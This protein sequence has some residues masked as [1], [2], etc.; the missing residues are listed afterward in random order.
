MMSVYFLTYMCE[1]EEYDITMDFAIYSSE[2]KAKRAMEKFKNLFPF[3]RN[4]GEYYID[5]YEVNKKEWL[6]GFFTYDTSDDPA[7]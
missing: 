7:K 3:T 6:E 4:S 2:K 1:R 5:R